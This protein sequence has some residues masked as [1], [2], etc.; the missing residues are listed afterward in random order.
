MQGFK[1]INRFI[2][3][4]VYIFRVCLRY[5][6]KSTI[7][8]ILMERKNYNTIYPYIFC[9]NSACTHFFIP[10]VSKSYKLD[11]ILCYDTSPL[12]VVTRFKIAL[13]ENSKR[14]LVKK[15]HIRP[16]RLDIHKYRL[17]AIRLIN[18][19]LK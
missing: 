15:N 16:I 11:K 2:C 13:I 4:A 3:K 12:R 9:V 17:T 6:L 19:L 7:I 5:K 10:Q 8:S 18:H 1:L 14:N